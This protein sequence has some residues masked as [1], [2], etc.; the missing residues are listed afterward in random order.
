MKKGLLVVLAALA[1]FLLAAGR[2]ASDPVWAGQCGIATHETVWGDYGWPTLLPIL[3]RPGTLVAVTNNPGGDYPAEARARGA[4]TFGF[5]V[6]MKDKIGTPGAPA[7]PSTMQA[8]AE[9]Q[10]Q[11]TMQRM[12][13]CTT[14]LIVENELFGAANVTPWSGKYAQYRADVLAYL[15]DLAALG[16]HP[17]LLVARSPYLGSSDAVAWWLQV[18]KVADVVR[19]D[20]IPAPGV[21]KLGPVLGNRLLR[22]RYRQ[23]VADFTSIGIPANRVGIMISVLSAK[24]GSGRSGLKP[25]SAWFQVVKWYAL[26]A[27]EVAHEVG[28]GS[29]FS[30]GWQQWTAKEVDPDKPKAACVWLWTRQQN[31]CNA[32]RMVGAGFDT[33]RTEGQII[34]PRGAVCST[35]HFGSIGAGEVTR[36]TAVS[37]DRNAALSA[38]FERLVAGHFAAA[39]QSSVAATVAAVV[40]DSFG[41]S[42]ARYLAALQQAHASPLLARAVLGDE[43]RRARI[44]QTLPVAKPTAREVSAFYS[45]Y[46]QLLVR[47][48]RISPKA[49]WLGGEREGYA[50]SG[51][52]PAQVFVVRS[53]RKSRVTTLLGAYTVKPIGAPQPLGALSLSAARPAITAALEVFERAKAF[54]QWTI[55]QQR[56][57]LRSTVCRADDLPQPAD[58]D[59]TQYLPFLALQ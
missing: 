27:K 23:A 26:S 37:G 46:P 10:Y 38:L 57:A 42:R 7:D 11:T 13:G 35:P 54:Q 33:S 50:L 51:A 14:P 29:V 34:L 9:K 55:V 5:D 4:A 6:H 43:I 41:G 30:W 2:A 47:R 22:E 36:L 31:L 25:A 3:A 15:Q 48:V 20:Y 16:A 17:A 52:A 24:G 32:P 12:G 21:W 8:A 28:L 45:E 56:G 49:A 58:V 44:E 39:S 59:L 40:H 18:A 19:E 1:A 53:G